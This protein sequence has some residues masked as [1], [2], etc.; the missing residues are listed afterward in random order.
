MNHPHNESILRLENVSLQATVG[1]DLLL[2]NIS[3]DFKR[4]EIIG[5]VGASGS[6]K[7][8]LLRLLNR[9]VS[10]S[11]GKIVLTNSLGANLTAIQWRQSIVLALQEPK[12]LGMKV[13]DTL[14]Y[15]L[16]LQRLA[17]LEIRRRVDTWSDLLGIQEQW[18]NKTELQLSLGQRQLVAIARALIMQPKVLLLDEPTSALDVGTAT[19]VLKV[20]K[21]INQSQDL[22][23]V[24]VNHQ[25][26]LIKGFCDRLLFLE[27]GKLIEDFP[28][29]DLH[30]ETIQQRLEQSHFELKEEW[31]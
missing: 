31:D 6:G 7:T 18:L 19:H 23:I 2:E 17:E 11:E 25:L 20:L 13:R 8:S 3:S 21:D 14:A 1:Y 26:E 28:A 9:L 22:T 27:R 4:G 15:P 24:M 16:K 29:N 10:P 30:W 5:I 12:L